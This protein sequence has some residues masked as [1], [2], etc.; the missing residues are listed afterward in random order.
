VGKL[1]Y[2]TLACLLAG[3]AVFLG[4]PVER[5]ALGITDANSA[6]SVCSAPEYA[7]IRYEIAPGSRRCRD[8]KGCS[9]VEHVSKA[10]LPYAL[11]SLHA[12]DA[13]QRFKL[14]TLD[15]EWKNTETFSHWNGLA[16]EVYE[17]EMP[18][19]FEVLVAFRGTDTYAA[20]IPYP[21]DFIANLSWITQYFNPW[22]QYRMAR[23]EF[24]RIREK[25]IANAKGKSVRFG[26]TG[27]SLGGGLAQHIAAG[28]PCV[29]SVVFNSSC[30]VNDWRYSQ[31]YSTSQI[32][33]V[34]ENRDWLSSVIC[35][36]G[37]MLGW[38]ESHQEYQANWVR[39]R[40]KD[41]GD[42]I[43]NALDQHSIGRITSSMVR[44]VV[45]CGQ[46]ARFSSNASCACSP[47]IANGVEAAQRVYCEGRRRVISVRPGHPC[48]PTP[49]APVDDPRCSQRC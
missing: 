5:T 17:K 45:C 47:D 44:K 4:W 18:D 34:Q 41:F 31:P 3:L 37:R 33:N 14:T 43:E 40:V 32:V 26:A 29:S 30:V 11:A 23:S 9:D 2:T 12:Y 28:F 24:R 27:H 35:L 36:P 19:A 21:N 7:D 6:A 39:D 16:F 8:P 1:F 15:P 38:Y 20:V 13:R 49:V 42:E 48:N 46:R 10:F 22:D 25:A